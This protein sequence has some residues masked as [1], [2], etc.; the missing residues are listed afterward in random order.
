MNAVSESS[1]NSL[2]RDEWEIDQY[3]PSFDDCVL[4][5]VCRPEIVAY[6]AG[7]GAIGFIVA[8]TAFEPRPAPIDVD[9]VEDNVN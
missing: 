4:R 2:P 5:G 7:E 1:G 8:P 3:W 6:I 9:V